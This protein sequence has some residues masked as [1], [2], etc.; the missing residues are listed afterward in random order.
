[1]EF[2]SKHEG[3]GLVEWERFTNIISSNVFTTESPCRS[4]TGY[5]DHSLERPGLLTVKLTRGQ[6]VYSVAT[7]YLIGADGARSSC[8]KP[9]SRAQSSLDRWCG[10]S[11]RECPVPGPPRLMC[12]LDPELAP[13][14]IG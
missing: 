3:F 14:Y 8:S 9:Q 13:G 7:R 5:L 6:E 4:D 11:F 2:V 10:K 1:M 12:F